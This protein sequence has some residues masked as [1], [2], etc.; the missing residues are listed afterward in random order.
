[1]KYFFSI[2]L[3][4]FLLSFLGIIPASA[5]LVDGDIVVVDA[6]GAA[7]DD[8]LL[9]RIDPVTGARTVIHDFDSGELDGINPVSLVILDY[10]K[11]N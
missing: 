6:N 5:M 11:T 4:V 10:F 3:S 2:L 8:G 9:F 7:G 1:M